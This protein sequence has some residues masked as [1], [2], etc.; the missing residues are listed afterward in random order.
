MGDTYLRPTDVSALALGRYAGK[1]EGEPALRTD[2]TISDSLVQGLRILSFTCRC[3]VDG[4]GML[5]NDD[6]RTGILSCELPETLYC[7]DGDGAYQ[8]GNHSQ[9]IWLYGR[10]MPD[11]GYCTVPETVRLGQYG[12]RRL[13]PSAH[14]H[15]AHNADKVI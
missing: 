12:N 15:L 10:V 1:T 4:S 9:Y 11:I 13:R 8:A 2:N 6:E 7:D 3:H 5:V 14:P